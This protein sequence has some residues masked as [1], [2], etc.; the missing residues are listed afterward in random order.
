MPVS[1]HCTNSTVPDCRMRVPRRRN[2]SHHRVG[3]LMSHHPHPSGSR[4]PRHTGAV[5]TGGRGWLDRTHEHMVPEHATN[6]HE[7]ET[8][9]RSYK[10]GFGDPC[11][12]WRSVLRSHNRT[13][14]PTPAKNRDTANEELSTV[15]EYLTKLNDMCAV[16]TELDDT[17]HPEHCAQ[18]WARESSME[19]K[20]SL[21]ESSKSRER[22][23]P[24]LLIHSG[25]HR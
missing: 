16:E 8:D 11:A 9:T 5:T 3:A 18:P 13:R 15:T 19:C 12:W 1:T 6:T 4:H 10:H 7:P 20:L 25:R 24:S 22:C 21:V 14:L 2:T 23:L 17:C